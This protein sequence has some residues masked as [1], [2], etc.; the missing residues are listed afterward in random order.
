LDLERIWNAAT[1]AEQRALVEDMVDSVSIYPDQI[2]VQVAGAPPFIVALDEVG[3]TQGCKP[4]VSEKRRQQHPTGASWLGLADLKTKARCTP[5][6]FYR[7]V[8]IRQKCRF[9]HGR[10]QTTWLRAPLVRH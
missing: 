6:A 5:R 8:T 3:L 2:T 10:T 9:A 4:V 1:P 7:F